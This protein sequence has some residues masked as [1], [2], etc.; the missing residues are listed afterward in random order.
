MIEY[1]ESFDD[2]S[3]IPFFIKGQND[4]GRGKVQF[5]CNL[6]LNLFEEGYSPCKQEFPE[7]RKTTTNS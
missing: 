5:C 2:N 7:V 1:N 6:N 4:P 3:I